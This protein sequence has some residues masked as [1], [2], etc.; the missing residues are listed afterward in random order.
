[1][2]VGIF[3]IVPTTQYVWINQAATFTCATNVTEYQLSFN[4]PAGISYHVAK[5]VDQDGIKVTVSFAVTSANNG[6]G[7]R[8]IADRA[9]H[10]LVYTKLQFAYA[11]GGHY[12]V[13]IG[14]PIARSTCIYMIM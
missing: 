12:S 1:M 8:C 2:L 6:S 3:A 14:H 11:Q 7:V 9:N 5:T 4:V 13:P 10:A